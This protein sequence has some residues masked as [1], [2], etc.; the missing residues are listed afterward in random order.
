MRVAHR[1]LVLIFAMATT[2]VGLSAL[3]MSPA[4]ASGISNV[5][6]IVVLMQENRSA[7]TYFGQ[8]SSEGQPSYEAEPTTGNPNP[9]VSG[10]ITPFHKTSLCETADLNHSWTGEHQGY[11]NGAM[12]GFTAANDINSSNA[13]PTDPTGART[14]GYYNQTDLPFYYSLYNTFATDDRYFQSVLGPTFPNRFYL[15]TGTSFGHIQNDAP[16]AGG[17]PQTTIFDRLG[18]AGISW[19]IYYSQFPFGEFFSY[20]QQH[21]DHVAPISQYYADAAAGTL[22]DVSFVDPIFAGPPNSETDEHPSSNVQVGQNF[23]YSVVNALE[24]SPNWSDSAMFMTYDENGGF[25]DHVAPPAA[26]APDNIAPMLQAGDTQASFD[27]Y[28]F[29]VPMVV[30]SPYSKSHYVSHVV[31]DHTSILK[32]IETRYGLSPLTARDAAADPMLDMFDFTTANFATPPTFTAPSVTPCTAPTITQQPSN[33]NVILGQT[34]TFTAAATTETTPTIQWQLSADHGSTWINIAGATSPSLSGTPPGLGSGLLFRAKFTNPI[35]TVTTNAATLSVASN[36]SVVLPS[37]G[38][39]VSGSQYLDAGAPPWVTKVQFQLT[40][41]ALNNTVVA[42]ATP[43]LFGWLAKWNTT[44]V[45]NGAYSL[46]SVA[47]DASSDTYTSDPI[48][49]TVANPPPATAVLIPSS[50]STQS[51]TTSLL[52]ASASA[53]VTQVIYE[54]SGGPLNLSNQIVATGTPTLYGWI[55]QWDTTAVPNGSY[56]LTSVASYAGGVTGTSSN[57]TITVSN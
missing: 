48:T 2:G 45:P 29:R 44:S 7:D 53:N 34:A 22:P 25:Y 49:I 43:T 39:T 12:D 8:L 35:G 28:G 23:A 47:T 40:G 27:R 10:T 21:L 30:V 37:G 3:S 14:M 5:N 56:V 18:A 38:A 11:D 16:P 6:H 19:K 31:D 9:L 13:D 41:G 57:V 54:V 4:G 20:V 50:G 33:Q 17:W 36:T 52:D 42:T 46:R 1:T 51:G 26:V 24:S 55:A 32:F 15:L